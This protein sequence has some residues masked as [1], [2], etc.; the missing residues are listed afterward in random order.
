MSKD[1]VLLASGF[2]HKHKPDLKIRY[3]DLIQPSDF[4]ALKE[5]FALIHYEE[6]EDE[7]GFFVTYIFRKI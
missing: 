2:G 3:E 6:C 5:D 7:R 4:E 1:G